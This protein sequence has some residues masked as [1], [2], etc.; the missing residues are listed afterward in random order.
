[1]I[2]F[3]GKKVHRKYVFLCF[4]NKLRVGEN[5]DGLSK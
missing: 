5:A 4:F 2:C 3:V 1:M